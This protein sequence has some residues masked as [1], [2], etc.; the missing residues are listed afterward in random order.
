M[1]ICNLLLS[2]LQALCWMFGRF[3]YL[4]LPHLLMFSLILFLL[5]S[6][7]LRSTPELCDQRIRERSRKE[8]SGIP[9][10]YLRDLHKTHEDWL[11][12][13]TKFELPAP[14][15][16]STVMCNDEVE[17]AVFFMHYVSPIVFY[18]FT[19]LQYLQTRKIT[20]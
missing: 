17:K 8:E 5:F 2:L 3:F 14:V 13:K 15:L 9:M 4:S 10:D 16:V 18:F 20:K 11:I 6:V 1:F 19:S 7:Y 12:R